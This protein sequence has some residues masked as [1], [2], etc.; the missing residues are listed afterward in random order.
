MEI[1]SKDD[2]TRFVEEQHKVAGM[3]C[4]WCWSRLIRRLSIAGYR[5]IVRLCIAVLIWLLLLERSLSSGRIIHGGQCLLA[6][7]QGSKRFDELR[8]EEKTFESGPPKM[9]QKDA[10]GG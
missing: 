3:V 6:L 10:I 9:N 7:G 5:R 1:S 4:H 2:L 8:K